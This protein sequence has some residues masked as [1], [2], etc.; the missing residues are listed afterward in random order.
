MEKETVGGT[1]T[2]Y[3]ATERL[4][5][6]GD[7]T[8][9]V[10]DGDPK[11]ATLYASVGTRIPEEAAI[12]FGLVKDGKEKKMKSKSGEKAA[13]QAP[14]KAAKQAPNKAAKQSANKGKKKT[15]QK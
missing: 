2:F 10:K 9:V 1:Q 15:A 7:K 3:I 13:K 4:W 14:N 8:E 6:T 11:A 12:R 5:L